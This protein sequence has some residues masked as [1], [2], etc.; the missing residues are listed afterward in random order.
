MSDRPRLIDGEW[1]SEIKHRKTRRLRD[2][3][4]CQRAIYE[5]TVVL[6]DRS[7][8]WL[9][10]LKE[11]PENGQPRDRGENGQRERAR[12]NAQQQDQR[13]NAQRE[14]SPENAPPQN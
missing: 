8:P 3:V 12:E 6:A 7:R 4:Y 2:W 14:K 1:R 11:L 13:D 9:G 5:I 10:E